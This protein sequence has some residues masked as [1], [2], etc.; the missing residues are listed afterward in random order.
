MCH[1]WKECPATVTTHLAMADTSI[2]FEVNVLCPI[3]QRHT[4]VSREKRVLI[5]EN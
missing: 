5:L 4:G 2:K 3:S 1:N